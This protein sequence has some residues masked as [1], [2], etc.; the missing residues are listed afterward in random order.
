MEQ[1][2]TNITREASAIESKNQILTSLVQEKMQEGE[3][4][5]TR[6]RMEHERVKELEQVLACMRAQQH[7]LILES[8]DSGAKTAMMKDKLL[9]LEEETMNLQ[10]AEVS[11]MCLSDLI[12]VKL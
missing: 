5:A 11:T 2:Q 6:F 1:K 9:S 7:Q 8:K 4:L 12:E 10:P 3:I